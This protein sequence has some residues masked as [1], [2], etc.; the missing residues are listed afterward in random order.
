M[1]TIT[2]RINDIALPAGNVYRDKKDSL[3]Y[4]PQIHVLQLYS[5]HIIVLHIQARS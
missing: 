4:Y 3:L 1:N 5:Q 2:L